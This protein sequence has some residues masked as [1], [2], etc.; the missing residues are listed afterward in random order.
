MPPGR[1]QPR[2]VLPLVCA[3]EYGCSHTAASRFFTA[4]PCIGGACVAAST[5]GLTVQLLEICS[6]GTFLPRAIRP[7]SPAPEA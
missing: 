6:V 1:E 4:C 3:G 5:G 7:H 2:Q